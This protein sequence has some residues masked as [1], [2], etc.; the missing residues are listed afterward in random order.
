MRLPRPLA[1]YRA[2]P[3]FD[4]YTDEQCRKLLLQ[5]R[6]RRGDA[7]WVLPLLAAIGF[8]AAWSV[9]ALGLV[10]IAAALL[11]L[12]LTRQS[13]LL[14]MFMI[15]TPALVVVYSWVRRG[16]LVR[17]VRRLM[18]GA[19][20]PFC[21]FSLVGLPVKINTVRCP[22]CGE[23]VRLTEHGIRQED[24]RAGLPYPPA[25]AGEGARRA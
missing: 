15:V 19:A 23:K 3:E 5:A 7:A 22:E 11:G 12:A 13:T 10:R 25:S 9:V 24:L 8:A 1:F 20:C 14:A 18:N 4:G 17:S 2:Y 21:E 6:L 16:M